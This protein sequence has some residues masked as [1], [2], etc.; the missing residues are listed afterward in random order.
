MAKTG[1][2]FTYLS[3][4]PQ[5]IT[6]IDCLSSSP[7]LSGT[8]VLT[9][10][11]NLTSF[12]GGNNDLESLIGVNSLFSIKDF[13]ITGT[14]TVGFNLSAFSGKPL[15]ILDIENRTTVSGNISS[16]PLS[17]IKVL[18][19]G[20]Q[21]LVTTKIYD[22]PYLNFINYINPGYNRSARRLHTVP[23]GG[24]TQVVS[25][26]QTLSSTSLNRI[27]IWSLSSITGSVSNLNA[28]LPN[29][30]SLFLR[31]P[32]V[33][34]TGNISG[35]PASL[36]E[37]L[38][39]GFN[40]VGGNINGIPANIK[41]FNVWGLNVL[42]GDIIDIPNSI[43][44]FSVA[45][46]T[47]NLFGNI[48]ALSAKPNL[49]YFEYSVPSF[50]GV[51]TLSG[52]IENLGP[53]LT[54]FQ[55]NGDP[56][57]FTLTGNISGISSNLRF[58]DCESSSNITGNLANIP[59]NSEL[60]FL[61]L[62]GSSTTISGD[63][64][65]LP[66]KLVWLRMLGTN[67]L[68]G[69]IATIP[70]LSAYY[71]I[72]LYGDN[73]I[74]GNISAF[75]NSTQL[76]FDADINTEWGLNIR[77]NNTL[78]GNL[79]S[80]KDLPNL[81]V[82]HLISEFSSVSGDIK[83]ISPDMR[84][85]ILSQNVNSAEHFTG[86]IKNLPPK[87]RSFQQRGGGNITGNIKDIP[88]TCT[89][90]IVRESAY[91]P[92]VGGPSLNT[93]FGDIKDLP[94]NLTNWTVY[95]DSNDPT[96]FITG[97]IKDLPSTIVT[98]RNVHYKNYYTITG[99]IKNIPPALDY[100][101]VRDVNTITGNL[102]SLST[103]SNI[104]RLFYI[105]GNNTITGDIKFFP[106]PTSTN[107]G[108]INVQGN[109]TISGSLST[110]PPQV[111]WVIIGG[112][113]NRVN[114]YYDGTEGRG[115]N[116]KTWRNPMRTIEIGP[117]LSSE[118]FP[119]EHLITL[120][121]DLTG[122][123]WGY[124]GASYQG[125]KAQNNCEA[126]ITS[127]YPEASTA[128]NLVRNS[129]GT[130]PVTINGPITATPSFY[131][132]FARY[133]TLNHGGTLSGAPITFT[134]NSSATY[135]DSNGILRTA[136]INEPRFDHDPITKESKGLLLEESRENL[137]RHSQDF[138]NP[139]WTN[140]SNRIIVTPNATVAPD[141]TNT[142]TMLTWSPGVTGTHSIYQTTTISPTG[143]MCAASIFV[144]AGTAKT[145][146][147][148]ENWT[149]QLLMEVDLTNGNITKIRTSPGQSALLPEAL[150]QTHRYLVT[151]AGNGWYR[152]MYGG[153]ISNTTW[154]TEIRLGGINPPP[155]TTI[156]E[157]YSNIENIEPG[158]IYVW[159]AQLE[160]QNISGAVEAG[161]TSLQNAWP[162]GAFASSYIPTV[163]LSAIREREIAVV[164]PV[165][166]FIN[167]NEGTMLAEGYSGN[168]RT[169]G[170]TIRFLEFNNGTT[171]SKLFSMGRGNPT[172]SARY[173][174]QDSPN[175]SFTTTQTFLSGIFKPNNEPDSY[176]KLSF[177]YRF[178]DSYVAARGTG[179]ALLSSPTFPTGI[180]HMQIGGG[181]GD[182]AGLNSPRTINGHIKKVLYFPT[183]LTDTQIREI[184][185]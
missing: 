123:S 172:D 166:S 184:S 93:I 86:D 178:N 50:A 30:S 176:A 91:L 96:K 87:M 46:S 117:G 36:R 43:E 171:N 108:Y 39:H 59:S 160:R 129:S 113:F 170:G 142:A 137:L 156:D 102:S 168:V 20:E 105:L 16:L 107:A 15:E 98:F 55:V 72:T 148:R 95:S 57:K 80:I 60:L 154:Q 153:G 126:I 136:N 85:F 155:G 99:D 140:L 79:S 89:S 162:F 27:F 44:H 47:S 121:V 94:R 77:G 167:V 151:P 73:T 14:N 128:I 51:N 12:E 62:E 54:A 114:K 174:L 82:L 13:K 78:T 37:L 1:I 81:R 25:N 145:V 26:I 4:G 58:F 67:T 53:Y 141:G 120:L 180:T 76:G 164:T 64:S 2:K 33:T 144:K 17:S 69:N 179:T 68:S 159:G 161:D 104:V 175:Y 88:T 169:G 163:T 65:K 181:S 157:W 143:T 97:D 149:D 32:N 11:I 130:P 152:I 116:K 112:P 28:T 70:N 124:S 35:V 132:N 183:R 182:F 6:K 158:S 29:L 48:S 8:V 56:N 3:G 133:K 40:T 18:S 22:H 19:L 74:T 24:K 109:N 125:I 61:D 147:F 111:D 134:R 7:Y 5:S 45:G 41:Y 52:S 185:I 83:D 92:G 118:P 103:S 10:F 49:K 63:V 119:Q 150:P 84:N 31:G 131:R 173:F 101:D 90:L 100:I 135:F 9:P 38:L 66:S 165:S 138:T 122:V 146:R 21:S 42:S 177:G 34:V 71:N 106:T 127:L 75:R 115:Y 139:V 110:L 23:D